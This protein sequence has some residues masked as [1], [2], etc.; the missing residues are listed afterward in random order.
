[1]LSCKKVMVFKPIRKIVAR[2]TG[3]LRL[4]VLQ[5]DY[6]MPIFRREKANRLFD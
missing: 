2:R 1:M 5:S 6:I 4:V 3:N